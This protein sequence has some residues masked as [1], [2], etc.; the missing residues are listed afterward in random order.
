[1]PAVGTIPKIDDVIDLV[2]KLKKKCME[3]TELLNKQ[4]VQLTKRMEDLTRDI[5]EFKSSLDE[6]SKKLSATDESMT[7]A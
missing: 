2:S 6:I 1:M 3:E 4:Q 5:V 7:L